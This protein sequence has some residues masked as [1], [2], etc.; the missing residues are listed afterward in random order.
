MQRGRIV[1]LV[2]AD[3][4]MQATATRYIDEVL[5]PIVVPYAAAVGDGFHLMHDNARPHV[6]ALTRE[7]L[8]TEGVDTLDWPAKSPDLNPLEHLWDTL[9]RKANKAIKPDTTLE[10]LR[11][12]LLRKWRDI[13]QGK[14]RHLVQ[15]MRR[16]IQAVIDSDGGHTKY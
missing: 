16:R 4:W 15:S 3:F 8:E 9:K 12:I 7:F 6:A 5:H 13:D 14:I 11:R 10:G 2:E 1:G